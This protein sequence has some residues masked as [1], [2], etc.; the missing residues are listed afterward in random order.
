MFKPEESEI[1]EQAVEWLMR[2]K[3]GSL[4]ESEYNQF[5]EWQNR[6]GLHQK[7][8]QKALELEQKFQQLPSNIAISVIQKRP[9]KSHL[10]NGLFVLG[11]LP[12]IYCLYWINQ[13]QQ[14]TADYRSVTG[15]QRTVQ[16]PDGGKIVLNTNSAIDV[17]YTGEQRK[18]ILRKGEIWIETHHD[19]QHRPFVV[20]TQQGQAQALGTKYLVK[21]N[22]NLS[23]VAVVKGAVK[24][25]AQAN[26]PHHQ[27]LN[28]GQ[29]IAFNQHTIQPVQDFDVSQLAWTKGLLM[30]DEVPLSQFVKRLGPYQKGMI[31]LDS[32][33]ENV[34]ISGTYPI[35]N[36]AQAYAMLE[37]TYSIKVDHY[38][39]GHVTRIHQKE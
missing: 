14:W 35:N 2:I 22:A 8:W 20:Y 32:D 26:L 31:Y 39:M 13:Q 27:I 12:T 18:I 33:I 17:Q 3:Q 10:N 21:M 34:K 30:V 37:H 1:L 4:T 5:E 11:L 16:L 6:S 24:V 9:L 15:E 7:I 28:M 29:Q 36:L 38:A 25:Q 19:S 23:Y